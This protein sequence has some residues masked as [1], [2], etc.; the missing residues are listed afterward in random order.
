MSSE[1]Y[2]DKLTLLGTEIKRGDSVCLQFDVAKLHTRNSIQ[3]PIFVEL[4]DLNSNT[5]SLE[6]LIIDT[7]SNFGLDIQKR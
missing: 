1:M 5:Q 2:K 7:S 6:E 3:V 4:R